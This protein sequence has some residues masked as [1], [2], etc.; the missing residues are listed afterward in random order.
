MI[1]I[2]KRCSSV[3]KR[4]LE[5]LKDWEA[6]LHEMEK[7]VYANG[8]GH[9]LPHPKNG[10]KENL[11]IPALDVLKSVKIKERLALNGN[12]LL[13]PGTLRAASLGE[14][15]RIGV[16]SI[17]NKTMSDNQREVLRRWRQRMIEEMGESGFKKYQQDLLKHGTKTHSL[18]ESFAKDE[19]EMFDKTYAAA[20]EDVLAFWKSVEP[21]LKNGDVVIKESEYRIENAQLPYTGIADSIVTR[22]RKISSL[23]VSKSSYIPKFGWC[24]IDW[25]TS[26]KRKTRLSQ[27][28]DEPLQIAAYAGALGLNKGALV[29]I[30]KDRPCD[31]I[32]ITPDEMKLYWK[33]FLERFE[34]YTSINGLISS[35]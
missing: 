14:N 23:Y 1:R 18:I 15:K 26:Q 29:K 17:L 30:Y 19:P 7:L 31:I 10:K 2:A 3:L 35:R 20:D 21:V 5:T 24:I 16:T 33:L 4:P 6:V 34:K 9:L 11:E 13:K 32:V 8:H 25:K 22:L 28:F 27:C 12:P